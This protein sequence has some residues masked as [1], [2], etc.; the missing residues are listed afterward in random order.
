MK[1]AEICEFKTSLIYIASAR[2]YVVSSCLKKEKNRKVYATE[3]IIPREVS[4]SQ[5][6]R[7]PDPR[8]SLI[9]STHTDPEWLGSSPEPGKETQPEK[10]T[11]ARERETWSSKL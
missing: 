2:Q 8:K 5:K 1:R 10:R 7:D 3:I 9:C 4:H 11:R 6:D